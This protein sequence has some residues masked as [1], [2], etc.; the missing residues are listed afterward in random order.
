MFA[1]LMHARNSRS[2]KIIMLTCRALGSVRSDAHQYLHYC[3]SS[4]SNQGRGPFLDHFA[5]S[6]HWRSARARP[7]AVLTW[8]FLE[9]S[10][11]PALSDEKITNVQTGAIPG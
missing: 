8:T 1:L 7:H 3:Q 4:L 9:S 6:D 11:H 10:P 2:L 5:P